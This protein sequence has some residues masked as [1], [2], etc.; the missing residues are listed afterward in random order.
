MRGTLTHL[1]TVD[2]YQETGETE[3]DGMG[4]EVPVEDWVTVLEGVPCRYEPA[5]QGY[6][7]EDQ[8]GRVYSTPRI[9]FPARS[10]GEMVDVSDEDDDPDYEYQLEVD[11]GDGWRLSLES[12]DGMFALSNVDVHYEGPQRPSHVVIEV[13]RTDP[14]DT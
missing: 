6:V 14:E 7:R 5:G 11:E 9:Y 1:A 4:G 10:A 3:D 8:G 12:V 2:Q 13:E